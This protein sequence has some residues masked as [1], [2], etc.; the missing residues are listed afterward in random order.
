MSNIKD[1]GV[2]EAS[3]ADAPAEAEDCLV[4]LAPRERNELSYL[5]AKCGFYV[6]IR[7]AI[8]LLGL[9][10]FLCAKLPTDDVPLVQLWLDLDALSRVEGAAATHPL[11]QWLDNAALHVHAESDYRAL[12]V[13]RAAVRA[14]IDRNHGRDMAAPSGDSSAATPTPP[15]SA[16]PRDTIAIELLY[17]LGVAPIST[18]RLEARLI[19]YAPGQIDGLDLEVRPLLGDERALLSKQRPQRPALD[20]ARLVRHLHVLLHRAPEPSQVIEVRFVLRGRFDDFSLLAWRN[21]MAEVVGPAFRSLRDIRIRRGSVIVDIMASRQDVTEVITTLWRLGQTDDG[22]SLLRTLDIVRVTVDGVT[23]EVGEA[24]AADVPSG[25]VVRLVGHAATL[26]HFFDALLDGRQEFYLDE[27]VAARA[28]DAAGDG[29]WL[30]ADRAPALSRA[31]P[32]ETDGLPNTVDMLLWTSGSRG[33]P[34][35][36]EWQRVEESSEAERLQ[37][38]RAFLDWVETRLKEETS[39][40]N[41]LWGAVIDYDRSPFAGPPSALREH[42]RAAL[43][44]VITDDTQLRA[45]VDAARARLGEG[46]PAD[47]IGHLMHAVG[48]RAIEHFHADDGLPITKSSRWGRVRTAVGN[49]VRG[50][51]PWLKAAAPVVKQ[52]AR[53]AFKLGMSRAVDRIREWWNRQRPS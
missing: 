34:L 6:T 8:L 53:V 9:D 27:L 31:A 26:K 47:F 25:R 14:R 24:P 1:R 13:L 21:M 38:E 15:D 23:I 33:N 17:D 11:L 40:R 36:G 35:L 42:L 20:L 43:L 48:W 52:V 28:I 4:L 29:D 30:M 12:T 32:T 3:P 44:E 39:L 51:V 2:S 50:R 37:R 49:L 19:A 41:D 16:P 18:E 7:R 46:R 45:E 5:A 10:A 22:T